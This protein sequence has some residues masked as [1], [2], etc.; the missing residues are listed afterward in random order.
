MDSLREILNCNARREPDTGREAAEREVDELGVA[1]GLKKQEQSE[2]ETGDSSTQQISKRRRVMSD[3]GNHSNLEDEEME[4]PGRSPE[5]TPER[6]VPGKVPGKVLGNVPG[7]E[8][9]A[10]SGVCSFQR[11]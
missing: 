8:N 7:K 5:Q 2:D 9:I 4:K 6:K 11:F 10:P 1:E 3:A